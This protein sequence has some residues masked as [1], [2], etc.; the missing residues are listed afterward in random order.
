MNDLLERIAEYVDD[1]VILTDAESRMCTWVGRQRFL[2]A[3]RLNRDPGLGPPHTSDAND[4]RGAHSEFAASVLLNK[5]WRPSIGEITN[6]D[7]GGVVQVR[8]T[9]I[10]TGRLIIKPADQDDAPFV[11]IVANM[12]GLRFRFAGWLFA[13]DAKTWP[14]LCEYGD[15]AHF[16]DQC[17][18][19]P[20]AALQA[21]LA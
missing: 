10:E 6:P 21:W 7:V 17:A 12:E 16:V 8:S 20:R 11:L 14:L 4:I 1:L 18:L 3:R 15:P 5:Y 2:N 13:R 19:L 9:I